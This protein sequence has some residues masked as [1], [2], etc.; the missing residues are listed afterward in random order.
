MSLDSSP[1]CR[2]LGDT[3]DLSPEP[4][5]DSYHRA[6]SSP[7]A[8]THTQLR[9]LLTHE[10]LIIKIIPVQP[11]V[12]TAG[13]SLDSD[14]EPTDSVDIKSRLVCITQLHL[15]EFFSHIWTEGAVRAGIMQQAVISFPEFQFLKWDLMPPNNAEAEPVPANNLSQNKISE[16]SSHFHSLHSFSLSNML[17]VFC[18]VIIYLKN[19]GGVIATQVLFFQIPKASD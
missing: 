15:S 4:H 8:R 12:R 17:V 1:T 16:L 9:S 18:Q 11:R 2:W 13:A 14:F 10:E 19:I 6:P 5:S 7:H 3:T